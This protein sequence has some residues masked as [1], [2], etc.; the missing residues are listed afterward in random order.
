MTEPGT[1]ARP[2]PAPRAPSRAARPGPGLVL[3]GTLALFAVTFGFLTYQLRSGNDPALG[4]KAL[5]STTARPVVVRR[6]VKHR[7]IT[8]VL[9]TPGASGAVTS[10]GAVT[11]SAAP[12]ATAPA[13]VV[14]SAS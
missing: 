4:A 13:P 5:A 7:V 12:V 9:P 1:A 14:T 3:S 11:T 6:I 2:E 8:R 10:S